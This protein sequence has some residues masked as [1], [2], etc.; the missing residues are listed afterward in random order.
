MIYYVFILLWPLIN[1]LSMNLEKISDFS[2]IGVLVLISVFFAVFIYLILDKVSKKGHLKW[3]PG[4]LLLPLFV[5]V[6]LF[7]HY[8]DIIDSKNNVLTNLPVKT[9]IIWSIAALTL[10]YLSFKLSS[11]IKNKK[12]LKLML[13]V[14]ISISMG[15]LGYQ[16]W[17]NWHTR[18]RDLSIL[19]KASFSFQFKE[20][21]NVYYFLI[22]AYARQDTLKNLMNFD[23]EYFLTE[24]KEKGFSVSKNALS[25]YHFTAA[26]LSA[27]MNMRYHKKNEQDILGYEQM[28]LSLKGDNAV[29]NVFR[30]NGYKIVNIPAHWHQ[31]TC[32]GNE[33]ACIKGKSFEIY[34]TFFSQTPLRKFKFQN[35]YVD[36]K[37]VENSL[38]LFE[39]EPKFIFVHFAQVHDAI[40]DENGRFISTFH[41][42]FSNLND[43]KRYIWSIQVMNKA[44]LTMVDK[45]KAKDPNAVI[46]IQADHGPTYVGNLDPADPEFWM[47]N[48]NDLRLSK[49][50]DVQ[51]TFGIFSATYLPNL[52]S[53]YTQCQ[54][55]F[56]DSFSLINTFRMLFSYLSDVEPKL[57]P[58][59]SYFLYYDKV[60][61]GYREAKD[62]LT[63]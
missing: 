50:E 11:R 46:I 23:N 32:Y 17:K 14:I 16:F 41:P 37:S 25:N 5:G 62:F 49:K 1:Y 15:D 40:F 38:N 60:A 56:S 12:I 63:K 2:D 10:C 29:R 7:F 45:I 61:F 39:N 54:D 43:S 27:T 58:D 13:I 18:E 30:K 44:L 36:E 24:L 47:K 34:T 8:A 53:R 21:P 31:M 55:Y 19:D 26:S 52:N 6:F 51:Y 35:H 3:E 59:Q 22:D 9:T 20:K 28:H 57:L 33:D 42:I 4:N 48:I